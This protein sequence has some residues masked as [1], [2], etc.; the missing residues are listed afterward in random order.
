M[1]DSV[2]AKCVKNK[3]AVVWGEA[4]AER[5]MSYKLW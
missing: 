4:G 2:R 1:L 3:Q 5:D